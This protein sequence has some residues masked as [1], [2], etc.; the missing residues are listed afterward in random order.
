MIATKKRLTLGKKDGFDEEIVPVEVP[1]RKGDPI[2][3]D[4]DEEYKAVKFEKIPNLRPAFDKNGTITAAN[5]STM[6]DGASALV[7][8]SA[9]K[10]AEL[11]L[12][13]IAKLRSFADAAQKQCL[14]HDSSF[15]G[16]SNRGRKS[17]IENGR[18]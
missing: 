17:W 6:N 7:L 3:F 15:K 14:V 13:P 16:S 10:A 12:K 1:Q 5:A 8:M 9:E 11:G 2:I 18:H 4:H